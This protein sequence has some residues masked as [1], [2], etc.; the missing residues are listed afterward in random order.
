M[1]NHSDLQ[2]NRPTEIENED[3]TENHHIK[4][5]LDEEDELHNSFKK[6]MEESESLSFTRLLQ[7]FAVY[8]NPNHTYVFVDFAEIIPAS[9]QQQASLLW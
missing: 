6:N 7:H 9:H 2:R 3:I 8:T 1:E 4:S 5:I